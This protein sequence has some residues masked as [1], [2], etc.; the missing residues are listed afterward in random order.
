MTQSED[1]TGPMDRPPRDSSPSA[2]N[3]LPYRRGGHG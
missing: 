1:D 3:V 2:T